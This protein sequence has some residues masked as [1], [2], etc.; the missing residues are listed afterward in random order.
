MRNCNVTVSRSNRICR[1][2]TE[3]YQ[4]TIYNP[5]TYPDGNLGHLN[6]CRN[7]TNDVSGAWCFTHFGDFSTKEFCHCNVGKTSLINDIQNLDFTWKKYHPF[8]EPIYNF[9]DLNSMEDVIKHFNFFGFCEVCNIPMN[10]KYSLG[11]Y[12]KI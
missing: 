9:S 10:D 5:K 6:F 2:W 8:P 12:F 11:T 7:P 3:L 4:D 1:N